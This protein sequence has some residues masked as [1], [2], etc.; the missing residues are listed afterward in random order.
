MRPYEKYDNVKKKHA[1][2]VR[3]K[4]GEMAS[5]RV[6]EIVLKEIQPKMKETTQVSAERMIRSGGIAIKTASEQDVTKIKSCEL[7]EKSR[8]KID[9]PRKIGP[10]IIIYDVLEDLTNVE[11]IKD[12]YARNL[13]AN[14]MIERVRIITRGGK[15][16]SNRTNVIIELPG[17]AWKYL[18]DVGRVYIG[19][20]SFKTNDFEVVPRCYGCSVTGID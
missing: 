13:N 2:V 6:K 8:L 12:L 16:G 4:E 15:K 18:L 10:K 11:L 20:N 3:P 7:F 5:E 1:I 19:W 14:E 17:K 9:A